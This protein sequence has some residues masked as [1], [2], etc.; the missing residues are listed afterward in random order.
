MELGKVFDLLSLFSPF[1]LVSFMSLL[2]VYNQ[3]LKALVLIFGII[4]L[5]IILK[6]IGLEFT[7]QD[8]ASY[9]TFCTMFNII[10]TP[11]SSSAVIAFIFMCLFLPMLFNKHYNYFL[12]TTLFILYFSDAFYRAIKYKC[13]GLLGWSTVLLSTL[14]GLSF[15]SL[16]F[17]GIYMLG[18]EYYNL[19]YFNVSKYNRVQC[20]KLNTREYKCDVV[21]EEGNIIEEELN[22]PSTGL[23][24][25]TDEIAELTRQMSYVEVGEIAEL[26]REIE[27]LRAANANTDE[28]AE[29]TQQIE[30]LELAAA[31]T[32][33]PP[34][35][36]PPD[37]FDGSAEE[38]RARWRAAA[39]TGNDQYLDP[40]FEFTGP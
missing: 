20:D 8:P 10:E 7:S 27:A 29:L 4:I 12:I 6:E 11:G 28:I 33:P 9:N 24:S 17:F 32:T 23:S 22:L 25:F 39:A 3:D 31:A 2:S 26:A 21:D 16:Y 30:A 35:P 14:I 38:W 13:Y 36:P 1:L 15:G 37:A 34:P 19:L 40:D 18:E 5:I